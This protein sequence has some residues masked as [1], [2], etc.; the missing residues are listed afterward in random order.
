MQTVSMTKLLLNS[1][2]HEPTLAAHNL[3]I[4][5]TVTSKGNPGACH[6]CKGKETGR[7]GIGV[8]SGS[9]PNEI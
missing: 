8:A 7:P 5:A 2:L 1:A 3:D 4:H 9:H 6:P